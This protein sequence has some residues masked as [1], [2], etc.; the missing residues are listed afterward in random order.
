MASPGRDGQ[1]E[2]NRFW[3]LLVHFEEVLQGLL[4]MMVNNASKIVNIGL[5]E[6]FLASKWD[7]ISPDMQC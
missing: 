3:S 5:L 6:L 7:R 4:D 2:N 1:E